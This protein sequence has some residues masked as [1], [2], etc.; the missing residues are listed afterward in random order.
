MGPLGLSLYD[1]LKALKQ[2]KYRKRV[3]YTPMFEVTL[4]LQ[5]TWS[6]QKGLKANEW[7]SSEWKVIR[8][9]QHLH[10]LHITYLKLLSWRNRVIVGWLPGI[11]EFS[12]R[13]IIVNSSVVLSSTSSCQKPKER[14]CH[15]HRLALCIQ[16]GLACVLKQGR[17]CTIGWQ[18][19]QLSVLKPGNN[20]RADEFQF[21]LTKANRERWQLLPPCYYVSNTV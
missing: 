7:I 3:I 15:F 8:Y 21:S 18:A 5:A 16:Y 9:S 4:S 13:Y 19:T 20:Q 11:E 6:I 17:L 10:H 1:I 14:S 2:V 12:F